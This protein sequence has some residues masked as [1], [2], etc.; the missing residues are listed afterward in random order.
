[1]IVLKSLVHFLFY[2]PG[3]IF[4]GDRRIGLFDCRSLYSRHAR[5]GGITDTLGAGELV[6]PG[7]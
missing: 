6:I 7:V 5:G 3:S 2:R 4:V 1:M